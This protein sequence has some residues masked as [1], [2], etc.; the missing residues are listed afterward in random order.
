MKIV[1]HRKIQ[2]IVRRP[3]LDV[4]EY[5]VAKETNKSYIIKDPK[6]QRE[7][8]TVVLKK[9]LVGKSEIFDD[10]GVQTSEVIEPDEPEDEEIELT[11]SMHHYPDSQV[12]HD[13]YCWCIG[14][15]PV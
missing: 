15:K 2:V 9:D 13:A 3:Y 11:G 8:V 10:K 6:Q 12:D 7:D 4:G 14:V 5:E 1:L